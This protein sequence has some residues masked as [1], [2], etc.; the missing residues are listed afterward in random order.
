MMIFKKT[1]ISLKQIQLIDEL[2]VISIRSAERI[3]AETGTNM[4]QFKNT[5]HFCSWA[6]LVP[7][8]KESAAKK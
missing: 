2:P 5:D 1:E 7:E 8:C 4:E 6:G 3:I